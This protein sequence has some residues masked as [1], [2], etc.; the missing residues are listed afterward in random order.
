MRSPWRDRP[1]RLGLRGRL[2]LWNTGV[3]LLM[4]VASLGAARLAARATLYDDADAEL[5]AGVREIVLAVWALSPDTDAVMAMIIRK[6]E[7]HA[8]RGWFVHVLIEDGTSL[9]QSD[10]CPQEVVAVPP[11]NLDREENVVQVGPYRYVR[12]RIE[13]AG[14]PALHVRLGSYT[15]GLDASL[16]SLVRLLTAVGAVLCVL[17]PLAGWWLARRATQPVAAMLKTADQLQ[18][19]RLGDRLVVRGTG[20]ELDR[21]AATINRLLDQVADYVDRQQRFVADAAHE[22]RGP[23]TAMRAALEVALARDRDADDYRETL[24][25]VLAEARS[26]TTLANALLTLAASEADN[27][28][29]VREPV[30]VSALGRQAA[31]M[32]AGVAEELG[33]RLE[34]EA[35]DGAAVLGDATQLRQVF[36][37]LLDNALRFTPA[38]GVVRLGIARPEASDE[39]VIT[40]ADTGQGIPADH[41][42]QVFDRFFKADPARTRDGGSRTGGLGLPIC[43]SIVE[44]HGGCISVASRPGQG[45][46]V[47]VRLPALAAAPVPALA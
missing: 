43:K 8:Q 3:V 5:R 24:A 7:S 41:L 22:L 15:T 37:N 28:H 26:L 11:R 31:G 35:D 23:L 6:A 20:D 18:P 27:R 14:Q 47:T 33:L 42:D 30:E 39:I 17:T 21:L 45:T 10:H 12:H 36:G 13:R 2:T 16:S 25:D 19:V 29:V 34:M 9:W 38:G 46:T 32:F 4:T 40:V 44:A 1:S